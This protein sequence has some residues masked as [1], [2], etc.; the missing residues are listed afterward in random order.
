MARIDIIVPHLDSLVPHLDVLCLNLKE[1][2][3]YALTGIDLSLS[4]PL[5]V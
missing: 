1:T 4:F 3:P 2:L 5:I